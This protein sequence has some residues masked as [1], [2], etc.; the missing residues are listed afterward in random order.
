MDIGGGPTEQWAIY[1]E[2]IGLNDGWGQ[3]FDLTLDDEADDD[4]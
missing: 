3:R 4:D 1:F 2:E